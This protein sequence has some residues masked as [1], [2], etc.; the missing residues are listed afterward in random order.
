M[1]TYHSI[2]LLSFFAPA[3]RIKAEVIASISFWLGDDNPYEVW[4]KQYGFNAS[5]CSTVSGE[6]LTFEEFVMDGVNSKF[7]P[8]EDE[9]PANR[10]QIWCTRM[11]FNLHGCCE[12]CGLKPLS[13]ADAMVG[14]VVPGGSWAPKNMLVECYECYKEIRDRGIDALL[15]RDTVHGC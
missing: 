12:I 9:V 10:F 11:G 14:R 1:H 13:F 6:R 4:C 3:R 2:A 15:Y 7:Y 5:T 8:S